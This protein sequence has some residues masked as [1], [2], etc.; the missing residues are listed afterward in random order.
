M[1]TEGIVPAADVRALA[2]VLPFYLICVI[3]SPSLILGSSLVQELLTCSTAKYQFLHQ[4]A[5]HWHAAD[6]LQAEVDRKEVELTVLH[7]SACEA[8]AQTK[9]G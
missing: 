2:L 1:L 4:Q 8:H 9:A 7:L 3:A 5:D 6:A